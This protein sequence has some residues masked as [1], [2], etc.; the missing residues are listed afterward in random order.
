MKS[1]YE[2]A[3]SRLEKAAPTVTLTDT[4][5]QELAELDSLYSAKI[6]ER[7]LLLEPEIAKAAGNPLEQEAL[8]KQLR[9]EVARLED[10][11]ETKKERVRQ[12][13]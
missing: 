7:R 5:K 8:Q 4:Q 9:S 1:A 13:R 12:G 10:E 2:L 3:M 11:R 6:A